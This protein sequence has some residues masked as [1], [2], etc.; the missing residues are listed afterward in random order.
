ML[1]VVKTAMGKVFAG[2]L[3]GLGTLLR[4]EF[5]LFLPSFLVYEMSSRQRT[6][7]TIYNFAIILITAS[8]F[9][10]PWIYRGYRLYHRFIFISTSST[11]HFWRG[12][13]VNATGGALTEDH[14]DM[15]SAADANFKLRIYS[16]DEIGRYDFFRDAAFSYIKSHPADF[17][18]RTVKKFIYFWSFSPQTGTEYPFQWFLIYIVFYVIL[19]FG[20]AMGIWAILRNRHTL[21]FPDIILLMFFCLAVSAAHSLYYVEMRHRWMIEP[22][23]LAISSYGFVSIKR[24]LPFLRRAQNDQ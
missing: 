6:R 8:L 3:I 4:P 14:R 9:I 21:V 23:L 1:I 17:L 16:L 5:I 2:F 15:F 24:A 12:N 13:N 20:F 10:L 7:K 22:I 19:A 11:E 18:K